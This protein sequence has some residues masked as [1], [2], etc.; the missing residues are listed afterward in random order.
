MGGDIEDKLELLDQMNATLGKI[1][2]V[3]V[4]LVLAGEEELAKK[5]DAKR[6]A[7]L[8]QIN[9]LRAQILD[10]WTTSAVDLKGKLQ[11]A[12]RSVQRRI[13]NIRSKVEVA[14]NAIKIIEQIDEALAFLK[15]LVAA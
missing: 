12:N 11:T 9:R 1:T 10:Q 2:N 5:M 15:N 3:Q 13:R 8:T 7:L 4:R 14:Q 6:K